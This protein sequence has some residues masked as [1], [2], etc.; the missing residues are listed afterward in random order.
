MRRPRLREFT[1]VQDSPTI[2]Q[3]AELGLD[4]AS[5]RSFLCFTTVSLYTNALIYH[6]C[7]FPLYNT[8]LHPSFYLIYYWRELHQSFSAEI[9]IF[10][11]VHANWMIPRKKLWFKSQALDQGPKFE[12]PLCHLLAMCPWLS[13]L[14]SLASIPLFVELRTSGLREH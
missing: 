6:M 2:I 3:L 13:Y 12:F 8:P 10:K 4:Q 14:M 7:F 11:S 9:C 5:S 1:R